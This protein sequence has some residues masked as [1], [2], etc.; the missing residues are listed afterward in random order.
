MGSMETP[1]PGSLLQLKQYSDAAVLAS[2]D[3]ANAYKGLAL[4]RVLLSKK[5][6]LYP[7]FLADPGDPTSGPNADYSADKAGLDRKHAGMIVYNLTANDDEELYVGMTQWDGT[8]W[9]GFQ[10][11]TGNAIAAISAN[12][13]SLKFTGIYENGKP[14]AGQAMYIPLNVSKPGAYTILATVK[15]A[16]TDTKDNGYYFTTSGLFASPG[17]YYLMVPGFGTPTEAT[18]SG[19]PG[20]H[21]T[22]IFNDH[23]ILQGTVCSKN[24][25]VKDISVRPNYT[26]TCS[27][28][29]VMGEYFEDVPL[30]VT[31][32]IE[33]SLSVDP[34]AFGAQFEIETDQVGGI[35]FKGSGTLSANPQTVKIY[36]EGTP[37]G[38]ND[39]QLYIRSN[40]ETNTGTCMATIFMI[41]P[42]KRLM[43]IG[44]AN[45]EG[46]AGYGYNFGRPGTASND[47]ITQKSNFGPHTYSIVR[48]HGFTNNGNNLVTPPADP[49]NDIVSLTTAYSQSMTAAQFGRYLFGRGDQPKIDIVII[50][51]MT[52]MFATGT[53]YLQKA[54]T[55]VKFMQE[56]GI[57]M[58]YCEEPQSNQ[59]LLNRIFGVNNITMT[60]GLG[61]GTRYTLGYSGNDEQMKMYYARNDDPI[62][63]GPFGNI[64]G[65]V[66]GED[67]STTYYARNLPMEQVVLYSTYT[68]AGTAAPSDKTAATLFRHTTLPFIWSGDG[69]FNASGSAS[70]TEEPFV[71]GTRTIN[72]RLYENFPT[73]KQNYGV[74]NTFVQN[75]V[76]TAN[77]LAWCIKT[78][79]ALKRSQK[80]QP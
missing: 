37:Y 15:D 14:L 25:F 59:N 80:Q 61:A 43:T 46:R 69:G 12:C 18:P 4:P 31:N 17:Y 71:V 48:Y 51:Y 50:G 72:G 64:A 39:K 21:V 40:S 27:L 11:Q 65:S 54:D 32:Y 55:L 73:Y 62:L 2:P 53:E 29:K 44:Q 76:F 13:D 75:A 56:G 58:M 26:M 16:A 36:G 35:K 38:D 41:I 45:I 34:S 19:N 66:W 78:S 42:P 74:A 63:D 79:E 10:G 20:D 67:A 30:N 3:N 24:I 49:G 1:A 22:I 70:L 57:V 52:N 8:K 9:V 23:A 7:M 47:M 60:A 33:L 68:A 6:Q 77:A 28:T 5:D